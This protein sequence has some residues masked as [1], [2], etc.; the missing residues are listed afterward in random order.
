M[1]KNVREFLNK[2]GL[3][4]VEIRIYLV[5]NQSGPLTI[6]NLSRRSGINRTKAYRTIEVMQKKGVIEE[7]IDERKKLIKPSPIANLEL[8]VKEQELKTKFVIEN[9]PSI[10]TFLSNRQSV[11]QPGT[12]VLFYRGKDGIRQQVWNTLR[13]EGT[14]L[15]YSY[16]PL[17]E[18]IG[19]FYFSWYE[20]W[21]KRKK[22]MRDLYSDEYI[23]SKKE[24]IYVKKRQIRDSL[25]INMG[26]IESR[27]ISPKILSINHQVDIYNEVV[28]LYNWHEGEVFG[29][30]IY[31]EKIAQMQKQLF[32][33]V[34]KLAGK[35]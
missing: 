3:T 29:V 33:I 18:L 2:L 11:V 4:D 5:L 7:I 31:N 26:N 20:E 28:S 35:A 9:Y 8:L 16:R 23:K 24:Y 1:E 15:G 12:K 21:V 22:Q 34:W 27:Y 17:V 19:E 6:L 32:E 25:D 14:L 30:E 10:A 13:V